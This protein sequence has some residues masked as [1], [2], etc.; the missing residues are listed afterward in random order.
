M[1]VYITFI[2]ATF[3]A[4]LRQHLIHKQLKRVKLNLI[5]QIIPETVL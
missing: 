4:L 1:S 3:D 2:L 5:L